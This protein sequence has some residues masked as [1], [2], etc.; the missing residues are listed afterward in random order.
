MWRQMGSYEREKRSL[1]LPLLL[2]LFPS[3]LYDECINQE[4]KTFACPFLFL[5][6]SGSFNLT[7]TAGEADCQPQKQLPAQHQEVYE[8]YI[9]H[10]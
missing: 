10:V 6:C 5:G 2:S 9:R 1:S 4:K 3:E 7:A 8:L